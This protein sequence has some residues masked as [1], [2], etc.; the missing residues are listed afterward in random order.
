MGQDLEHGKF[1]A[2]V[3][4]TTQ[5]NVDLNA[6][7]HWKTRGPQVA[8]FTVE[9]PCFWCLHIMQLGLDCWRWVLRFLLRCGPHHTETSRYQISI[10]PERNLMSFFLVREWLAQSGCL[11]CSKW[12]G[13]FSWAA[14]QTHIRARTHTHTL[15]LRLK[16]PVMN[17]HFQCVSVVNT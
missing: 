16:V 9:G 7:H 10:G 11:L 8:R 6:F 5:L 4:F 1:R 13:E 14:R 3:K 15:R 17:V 2:N 12:R